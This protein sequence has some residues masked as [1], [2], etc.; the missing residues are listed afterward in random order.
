MVTTA[1]RG[2]AKTFPDDPLVHYYVVTTQVLYYTDGG[3]CSSICGPF[4]VIQV[5]SSNTLGRGK[6]RGASPYAASRYLYRPD[7]ILVNLFL[8]LQIPPTPSQNRHF[9]ALYQTRVLF[10]SPFLVPRSLRLILRIPFLVL[11]QYQISCIEPSRLDRRIH[12]L[13]SVRSRDIIDYLITGERGNTQRR[14]IL[15]QL[16]SQPYIRS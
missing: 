9:P 10:S 14:R 15:C 1:I 8:Q 12:R 13:P 2:Q 3:H 11:Q 7:Q 4:T 5:K 16:L 6:I